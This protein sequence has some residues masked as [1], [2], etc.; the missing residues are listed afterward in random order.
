MYASRMLD[1]IR[2]LFRSRKFLL[3][4]VTIIASISVRFG[5]DLD[6]ADRE[7]LENILTLIGVM[8]GAIAI[9]DFASKLRGAGTA[10]TTARTEIRSSGV[11]S[12]IVETT[13]IAA[14]P[15][16]P[17]PTP[18]TPPSSATQVAAVGAPSEPR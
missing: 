10:T 17:A 16:S 2:A 1:T 5:W 7:L 3:L 8:I 9:E 12:S 4:I 13:A 6:A 15:N 14:G 11:E 18:P